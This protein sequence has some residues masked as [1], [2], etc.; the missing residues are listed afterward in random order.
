MGCVQRGDE[1][2]EEEVMLNN[3]TDNGRA[4]EQ[5]RT[6]LREKG[7]GGAQK[8]VRVAFGANKPAATSKTIGQG[9]PPKCF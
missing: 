3:K 6:R 1:A 8:A 4:A 5:I 2:E 7:A 9:P